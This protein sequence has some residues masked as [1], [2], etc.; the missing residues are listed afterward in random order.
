L[1]AHSMHITPHDI[2]TLFRCSFWRAVLTSLL[3]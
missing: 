3:S 1:V 2:V